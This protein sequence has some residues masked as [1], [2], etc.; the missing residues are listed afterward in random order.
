MR[1]V[2]SLPLSLSTSG[3]DSLANH[4]MDHEEIKTAILIIAL[5]VAGFLSL[6][7]GL[8]GLPYIVGGFI[9]LWFCKWP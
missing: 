1:E 9:G 6:T 8:L 2:K 5:T 3:V 7:Y 4:T